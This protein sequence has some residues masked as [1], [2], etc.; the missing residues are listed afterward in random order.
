MLMKSSYLDDLQA[1]FVVVGVAALIKSKLLGFLPVNVQIVKVIVSQCQPH[2][3][4][5]MTACDM[6]S[7]N[8]INPASDGAAAVVGVSRQ[9]IGT[10]LPHLSM[11]LDA[12]LIVPD[13]T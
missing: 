5:D 3:Q 10:S 9:A 11:T 6:T 4:D 13:V 7:T 12:E 1:E 2:L 8:A